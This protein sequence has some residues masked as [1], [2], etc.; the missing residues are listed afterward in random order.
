M[1][2]FEAD[3]HTPMGRSRRLM[4]TKPPSMVNTPED[5]VKI[6]SVKTPAVLEDS[7][8]AKDLDGVGAADAPPI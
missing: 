8:V 2:E 3:H 1:N 5:A 7:A 4:V 6:A